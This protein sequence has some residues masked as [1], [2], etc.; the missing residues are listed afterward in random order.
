MYVPIFLVELRLDAKIFCYLYMQI[1]YALI[2][3]TLYSKILGKCCSLNL[4]GFLQ[5][6]YR[7]MVYSHSHT[8][9]W[10]T[11]LHKK[12]IWI[13]I[14]RILVYW[15]NCEIYHMNLPRC[16]IFSYLLNKIIMY[17]YAIQQE[18]RKVLFLVLY[19]FFFN[20]CTIFT[21]C[22]HSCIEIYSS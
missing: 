15:D 4:M 9:I 19:E 12:F 8:K 7:F 21:A 5:Y 14:R 6:M 2:I 16:K 10:N 3:D 13:V 17:W 20:V 1:I 22:S 18:H 11:F